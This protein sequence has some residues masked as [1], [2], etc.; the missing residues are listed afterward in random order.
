MTGLRSG[1]GRLRLL[2]A[3][4]GGDGLDID[5]SAGVDAEHRAESERPALRHGRIRLLGRS[6]RRCRWPRKRS[7]DGVLGRP[8]FLTSSPGELRR[9]VAPDLHRSVHLRVREAGLDVVAHTGGQRAVHDAAAGGRGEE[10]PHGLARGRSEKCVPLPLRPRVR[11]SG[12]RMSAHVSLI[13]SLLNSG[14]RSRW[15]K[16]RD[17]VV[18]PAPGRPLTRTTSRSPE[19]RSASGMA[20]CACPVSG[21]LEECHHRVR[22][23]CRVGPQPSRPFGRES[24]GG[25]VLLHRFRGTSQEVSQGE[26]VTPEVAVQLDDVGVGPGERGPSPQILPPRCAVVAQVFV[27]RQV[28]DLLG[29]CAG[30]TSI[31]SS[32]GCTPPSW[33]VLLAAGNRQSSRRMRRRR[34]EGEQ[35]N[36]A[37]HRD[38]SL[39]GAALPSGPGS[40]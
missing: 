20:L 33:S 9:Y 1:W 16:G 25:G 7:V 28:G 40:L 37:L 22:L 4:P 21:A 36:G 29:D 26:V 30:T 24:F 5:G 11:W 14:S 38:R 12:P 19:E 32:T 13:R 10:V 18:F 23:R 3:A 15:A 2:R 31:G 39:I 27:T 35:G 8:A 17:R 6:R 34:G